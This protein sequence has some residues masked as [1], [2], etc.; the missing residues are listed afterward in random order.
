MSSE[1]CR[2]QFTD[3]AL[4]MTA[5]LAD[6]ERPA[7][8]QGLHE[9]G[10]WFGDGRIAAVDPNIRILLDRVFGYNTPCC[11]SWYAG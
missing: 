5:R 4:V 10:H 2:S 1:I 8:K 11:L 6:R 3:A 7:H 9:A